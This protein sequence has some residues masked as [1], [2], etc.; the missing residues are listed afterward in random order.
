MIT[1]YKYPVKR[2]ANTYGMF[3]IELPLAASVRSVLAQ[4]NE[5]VIYVQLDTQDNNTAMRKFYI[6]GTGKNIPEE[7]ATNYNFIGTVQQGFFVWHIYAE[8]NK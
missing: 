6:A 8:P 4:E 1:I 7:I 2:P 5:I 3:E